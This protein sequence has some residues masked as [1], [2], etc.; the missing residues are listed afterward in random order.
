MKIKSKCSPSCALNTVT[1]INN[2]NQKFI[3]VKLYKE[4]S[5]TFSSRRSHL[6]SAINTLHG[7]LLKVLLKLKVFDP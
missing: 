1:Q 5:T 7:S 6:E 3:F 2:E 4:G